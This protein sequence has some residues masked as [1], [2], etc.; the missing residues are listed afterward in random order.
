MDSRNKNVGEKNMVSTEKNIYGVDTEL[1]G[2]A[3]PL[4]D[5]WSALPGRVAG[6]P[7]VTIY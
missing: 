2:R 1:M 3:G 6:N 7:D 5:P 4:G